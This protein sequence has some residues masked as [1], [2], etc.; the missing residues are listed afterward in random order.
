MNYTEQLESDRK[1]IREAL[2]AEE[3]IV[4]LKGIKM[5][6]LIE[7]ISSFDYSNLDT[8][9]PAKLESYMGALSQYL[10]FLQKHVNQLKIGYDSA[11]RT[12]QE[13]IQEESLK[14]DGKTMKEKEAR[15]SVMEEIRQAALEVQISK[16][17]LDKYEKV[18]DHF[19]ELLQ[20]IKKVYSARISEEPLGA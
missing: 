5:P 19:K 2:M 4:P 7:E 18:P 11:T 12:Y 16:A 20:S 15:A 13:A 8:L 17:R 14:K 6:G 3:A 9:S 1:K 10:I